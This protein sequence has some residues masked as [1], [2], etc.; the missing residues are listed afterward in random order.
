MSQGDVSRASEDLHLS[1]DGALVRAVRDNRAE[2]IRGLGHRLRCVPRILAAQNARMGAPLG[3]HDLADVT[4]DSLVIIW[5]KLGQFDP[6][7]PFESWVYRICF[8]ELQNHLRKLR[9]RSRLLGEVAEGLL[10]KQPSTLSIAQA[11]RFEL[12]HLALNV[13]AEDEAA[14][15][16]MRHFEEQSFQ[17]VGSRLSIP[18]GT[19]KTRYYRGISKLKDYVRNHNPGAYVERAAQ[20]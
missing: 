6:L 2:A 4:Q 16:R 1:E 9:R 3:D 8:L 12:V 19:A 15:I 14:I 7:T 20:H 5:K 10:A 18:T 17:E 13:L 11:E